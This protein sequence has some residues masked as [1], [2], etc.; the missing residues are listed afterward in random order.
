MEC[1]VQ[2]KKPLVTGEDGLKVLE[3]IEAARSSHAAGG[4]SCKVRNI[5]IMSIS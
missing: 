2:H 3:I 1:V 4:Q 5:P